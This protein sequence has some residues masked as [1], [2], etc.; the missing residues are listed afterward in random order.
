MATYEYSMIVLGDRMDTAAI[1]AQPSTPA[2]TEDAAKALNAL[3][4]KVVPLL[5]THEGGGWDFVSHQFLVIGDH[6]LATFLIRKPI[7]STHTN[8]PRSEAG[9]P[10]SRS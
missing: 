7:P 1:V 2:V 4:A 8:G 5:S 3:L 9:S 10:R 6:L